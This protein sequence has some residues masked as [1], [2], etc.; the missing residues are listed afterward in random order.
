LTKYLL[1]ALIQVFIESEP[2][3]WYCLF[4]SITCFCKIIC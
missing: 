3:I 1:T 2:N 4:P